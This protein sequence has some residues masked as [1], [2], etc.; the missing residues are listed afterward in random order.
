MTTNTAMSTSQNI[1]GPSCRQTMQKSE[2]NYQLQQESFVRPSS[3][4]EIPGTI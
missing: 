2:E 3:G 4:R 1:I